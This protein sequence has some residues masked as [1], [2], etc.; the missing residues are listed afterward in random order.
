[1]KLKLWAGAAG[2]A[3]CLLIQPV[4][5][6]QLEDAYAAYG[7]GEYETAISLFKLLAQQG[8]EEAQFN[9]GQMYSEG[10]GLPQRSAQAKACVRT[11]LC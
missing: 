2:I 9:L 7:K 8:N 5:A 4:S 11:R 10:Q 3:W 1:M 6:G